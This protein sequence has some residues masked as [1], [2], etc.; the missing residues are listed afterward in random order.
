MSPRAAINT[1]STPFPLQVCKSPV[2]PAADE[3]EEEKEEGMHHQKVTTCL[4]TDDRSRNV[5]HR[6]VHLRSSWPIENISIP[7]RNKIDIT[8]MYWRGN[9]PKL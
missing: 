4:T 2:S 9:P 7:I 6:I 8:V 3:E 1:P 5:L